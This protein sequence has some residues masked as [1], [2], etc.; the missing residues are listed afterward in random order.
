MGGERSLPKELGLPGALTIGIGT[1]IGAGIF[2]LPAP[3]LATA[4]PAAAVAFVVGGVVAL[5]TA[6]S[7]SELGTAMPK[8][9]G[10]YYYID[11]ALGP[12]FGTVAGLGNWVGLAAATAFYL[13]GFGSYTALA[14]PVPAVDL[15]VYVLEPR[16]VSALLAGA[17][18]VGVNYYGTKET[19]VLQT[20]I[21]SVLVGILLVFVAVGIGRVDVETLR[22]FAPPETGGWSAVLPAAGLIFVTYL[23]FAEINTAA[24][25]LVNPD[26]NLPLAVLGSL[27][28]V[29]ALY[30]VVMIVVAGVVDY[31]V[32]V[33]FG[34]VAVARVAQL[35]LGWPGLALLTF[36]GLL[37]TASSAN[38]S[39]LASSRINYAMGR[40]RIVSDRLQDVHP[41]FD[42]PYRSI[43]L[44]GALI[45]GFVLVG[46]V[47][48]LA[49]AGSIL[50]LIVYGLLNV[51]LIVY[52]ETDHP[53]YDP[54]F[55][56][57]LYPYVPVLGAVCSF[58][59]IGFMAVTEIALSVL[60]VAVGVAWYFLYAKQHT[61]KEGV[62]EEY[63]VE[64]EEELPDALVSTI[65]AVEPNL[66]EY[67]VLVPF[68]DLE[69]R[70]A[71][72]EFAATRASR[73]DGVVIAVHVQ[74]VPDQLPITADLRELDRIESADEA[75][76][77]PVREIT[78]A[79]GVRLETHTL[80]TRQGFD[81]IFRA[82]ETYDAD[83]AVVGWEDDTQWST[84]RTRRG[85]RRLTRDF[86]CDFVVV[87]GKEF[88]PS[89]ILLP[90]GGESDAAVGA[91]LARELRDAYGSELHLL[92][93]A[94]DRSTG[95]QFLSE[96]ALEHGLEDATQEVV[97]SE[98]PPSAIERRSRDATLVI[99][100]ATG[101]GVLWRAV[102]RST[103]WGLVDDVD[104]TV[105]LVERERD[106]SIPEMVTSWL[107]TVTGSS[108]SVPDGRRD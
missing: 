48:V 92:H 63:A 104:A 55:T 73:H 14:L 64:H 30:A 70:R 79:H 10:A 7:I 2:V 100:G 108:G 23:G 80:L 61:R 9:G 81:S 58:G 6:L 33:D 27:L 19:G 98:D 52:R 39:I 32:A 5:F 21:V 50:H 49:K 38:A 26:R 105:V 57:P 71:V 75:T 41:T 8:A 35:M 56:T 1:M 86:P 37:A 25:E 46:D 96:W 31:R 88:D 36:A 24:E 20:A 93:V 12:L 103:V 17:A 53:D 44:T 77:D 45:F 11:D 60:F 66:P 84:S 74:Q 43:A 95:G 29:T 68:S 102:R 91:K 107:R 62:F 34:D 72:L 76:F 15:V 51:A 13:I 69:D 28:V 99:L 97:V 83:A 47:E 78:D 82:A 94:D 42:T 89:R 3:A 22:P 16:Q 101:E 67:R 87:A 59:L 40:D 65:K 85:L 90:T 106:R 4:G 18:F 54:G